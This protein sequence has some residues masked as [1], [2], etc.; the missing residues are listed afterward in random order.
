MAEAAAKVEKAMAGEAKIKVE[1]ET[2]EADIPEVQKP[3]PDIPEPETPEVKYS[4]PETAEVKIPEPETPEV[5]IPEPETPEVE[6][7]EPETPEVEISE[8]ETPEAEIPVVEIPPMES[9]NEG[10]SKT[11]TESAKAE[12]DDAAV[13]ESVAFGFSS[14]VKRG[15]DMIESVKNIQPGQTKKL[16]AGAVGVFGLSQVAGWTA[17]KGNAVDAVVAKKK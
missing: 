10:S 5:K 11:A 16:V 4:E 6:I 15:N 3:E 13:K 17:A 2:V 9:S 8:P 7:P 14:I 12:T 1:S